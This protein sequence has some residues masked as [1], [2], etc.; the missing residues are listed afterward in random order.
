M[1]P[2]VRWR[3]IYRPVLREPRNGAESIDAYLHPDEHTC[4]RASLE[5]RV[6][7]FTHEGTLVPGIRH[8]DR[9][10]VIECGVP[11][12]AGARPVKL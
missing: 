10:G 4:L 12:R 2:F 9:L 8:V 5:R 3:A 1:K 6:W 11:W 7:T